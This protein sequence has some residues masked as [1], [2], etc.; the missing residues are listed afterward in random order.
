MSG[1]PFNF[2]GNSYHRMWIELAL[3]FRALFFIGKKHVC[4]CCGWTLRAFTHG[5]TSLK[6]R[7]Y[8]YCPRCNSKSRHRRDWLFLKEKTNLFSEQLQ[9]FHVSPKYALSRCLVKMPNI[10]YVGADL[11]ERPNVSVKVD[12]TEIPFESELFDAIIC[13]HVL[14]H[15]END[16]KAINE[17]FR[18]LKPG[19]WAVDYGTN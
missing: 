10:K 11:Q 15:V 16:R 13:I 17:L 5:G 12:I 6:V 9:L 14:E 18:I 4:P 1:L 19:G 2:A 7:H 8:G 3:A